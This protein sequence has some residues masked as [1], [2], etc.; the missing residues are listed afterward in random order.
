MWKRWMKLIEALM[1]RIIEV[2]RCKS[3]TVILT[4]YLCSISLRKKQ[5]N[6]NTQAQSNNTDFL[7]RDQVARVRRWEERTCSV[8]LFWGADFFAILCAILLTTYSEERQWDSFLTDRFMITRQFQLSRTRLIFTV[9]QRRERKESKKG[10]Y[11][12]ETLL[13]SLITPSISANNTLRRISENS[14]C[15]TSTSYVSWLTET[16]RKN[17]ERPF[18]RI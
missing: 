9:A 18:A 16:I 8:Q 6:E 12:V 2:I 11:L 4:K 1:A 3:C 15:Q 10:F 7:E 5:P 14:C 13:Y 17:N